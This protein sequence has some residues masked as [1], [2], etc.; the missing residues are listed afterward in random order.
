MTGP[1]S[2]PDTGITGEGSGTP[3]GNGQRTGRPRW[4]TA[5][6]VI[7]VI[8]LLTVMVILHLTGTLGAGSHG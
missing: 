4:K 7:V 1:P 3:P 8:A 2:Y 6:I 5:A